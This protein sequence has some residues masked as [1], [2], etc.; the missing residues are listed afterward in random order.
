MCLWRRKWHGISS[1]LAWRIPRTEEPGGL[2]ATGSQE[3]NTTWRLKHHHQMC[4]ERG[5]YLSPEVFWFPNCFL[6]IAALRVHCLPRSVLFVMDFLCWTSSEQIDTGPRAANEVSRVTCAL[7][8]WCGEVHF[9]Y[10]TESFW[11]ILV[12]FYN[13]LLLHFFFFNLC[14]T[15]PILP[16][17]LHYLHIIYK[18]QC[19][20]GVP[21]LLFWSLRSHMHSDISTQDRTC[22]SRGGVDWFGS[23]HTRETPVL[24]SR[25]PL[26]SLPSAPDRDGLRDAWLDLGVYLITHRKPSPGFKPHLL[27]WLGTSSLNFSEPVFTCLTLSGLTSINSPAHWDLFFF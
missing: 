21:F 25:F 9:L 10:C 24:C 11:A 4:S 26:L 17:S 20:F 19:P 27:L 6:L 22:L 12:C 15:P 14:R 1:I 8:C 23:P 3:S 2:Q 18:R 7:C 5:E 16:H 13:T